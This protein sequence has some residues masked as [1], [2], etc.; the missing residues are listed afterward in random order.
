MTAGAKR[1]AGVLGITGTLPQSEKGLEL[2]ETDPEALPPLFADYPEFFGRPR[3]IYE[4]HCGPGVIVSALKAEGHHVAASDL[5]EYE[6]RWIGGDTERRWKCDFFDIRQLHPRFEAIVMNPP[7]S[8]AAAHIAHGLT[9]V[10]RIFALVELPWISGIK[11]PVRNRL[12]DGGHQLA[13]HPFRNR[14]KMHRDG[15]AGPKNKNTRKHAWAVFEQEAS[16]SRVIIMRRY[17][18]ARRGHADV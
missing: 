15:Y 11:C 5:G 7:Y 14:L 16:P 6:D 3:H 12:V 1:G 17:T 13:W 4:P 9:L 18:A 2:H 8:G 10:P